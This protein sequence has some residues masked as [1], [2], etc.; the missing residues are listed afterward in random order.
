MPTRPGATDGHRNGSAER[1]RHFTR[2]VCAFAPLR[3]P[4]L[5]RRGSRCRTLAAVGCATK[6]RRSGP[7]A[8]NRLGAW[9]AAPARVRS[10]RR[11]HRRRETSLAEQPA[12]KAEPDSVRLEEADR[13]RATLATMRA[14]GAEAA[15]QLLEWRF[16]DGLSVAEIGIRLSTTR[17][18]VTYRLRH[19]KDAFRTAW[20][21]RWG[22]GA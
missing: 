22:G 3:T 1:D 11:E 10:L 12:S 9:C 8:T 6:R 21:Q 7:G 2:T 15:A 20:A 19:A 14:T 13:A 16:L 17:R 18:N 5:C 4:L